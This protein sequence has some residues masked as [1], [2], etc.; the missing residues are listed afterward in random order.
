MSVNIGI[1]I[2]TISGLATGAGGLAAALPG[3]RGARSLSLFLGVAAGIGFTV[4]FFDLL[5]SAL[6]FGRWPVVLGGFLTGVVLGRLVDAVLPHLHIG[7][8][9]PACSHGAPKVVKGAVSSENTLLKTGYLF[10]LSISLHNFPEGLAIGAGFEA[11]A[12]LGMLLAMAIGIHNIPEGI[13]LS[14]VLKNAGLSASQAILTTTAVG[15]F[16][17]VGALMGLLVLRVTPQLLSFLLALGAGT[18][19]Y[20][21]WSELI[22]ESCKMHMG[23]ARLG[24]FFGFFSSLLFSIVR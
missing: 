6:E 24:L 1:L 4:V 5:P 2:S 10:A 22:P 7:K 13:A 16:I 14:S 9:C 11:E 12:R 8:G 18:L 17:P 21:I 15:L 23:F 3:H 19:L 20:V